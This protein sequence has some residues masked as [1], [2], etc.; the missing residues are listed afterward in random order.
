MISKGAT[1]SM[2]RATEPVARTPRRMLALA[3]VLA[4]LALGAVLAGTAGGLTIDQR[5]GPSYL[6]SAESLEAGFGYRTPYGD[7][8][9]PVDFEQTTSPVID[10]PPGYPAMLS[11][12]LMLGA[13]S[14]A[15]ARLVGA[16]LVAGITVAVYLIA[17]AQPLFRSGWGAALVA[18][19]AA[20]LTM[21][22]ATS[23]MSE[24]LYGVLLVLT[25]TAA[26]VYARTRRLPWLMLATL[27]AVAATTVRTAGLALV[28]TVV[29]V[30]W[31]VLRGPK[32]WL[33]PLAAGLAGVAP[34]F[35][36]TALGNRVLAWHPPDVESI[37]VLTNAVAE[38]FV[39]P[40]GPPTL[41]VAAFVALVVGLLA[42]AR[43]WT[44]RQESGDRDSSLPEWSVALIAAGA[45]VAML[46]VTKALFSFQLS[47][48]RRGLYPVA[49]ALLLG[50]IGY[51]GRWPGTRIDR[52]TKIGSVVLGLCC[53]L[54]TSWIAA[55]AL[56]TV[57][58]GHRGFNSE[59][60][61]Q[62]DAVQFVVASVP[63]HLV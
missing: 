19:I 31:L 36:S 56:F 27:W 55:G 2:R 40:V 14:E 54:A 62:S 61:L 26:G 11:V 20:A 12:G 28:A 45:H 38:W 48:G 16:L 59:E 63:G 3:V 4:A 41:R 43:P 44:H 57:A 33:L 21:P 9:K 10:F 6:S 18:L 25:V 60:F 53:L 47:L 13:D 29:I 52:R 22:Y 34:F 51:L 30:A 32:R 50:L 37:K 5:D 15:T 35:L 49:L 42:W 23:A 1:R 58:T 39:P 17:A 8:G 7:P 46:I 24:P